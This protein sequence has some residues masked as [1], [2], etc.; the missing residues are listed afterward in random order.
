LDKNPQKLLGSITHELQTGELREQLNNNPKRQELVT[1][2]IG[3]GVVEA[4]QNMA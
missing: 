4:F 3:K 2:S 1:Q